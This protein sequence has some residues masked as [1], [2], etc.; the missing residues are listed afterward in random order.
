MRKLKTNKRKFF[1]L[2]LN[3]LLSLSKATIAYYDSERKYHDNCAARRTIVLVD[4]FAVARIPDQKR[5]VLG[6]YTKEDLLAT[7][8]DDEKQ[9]NEWLQAIRSILYRTPE[10]H[11]R[12]L[13]DFQ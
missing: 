2:R 11:C 6:I 8:C 1:V 4:C 5:F 3:S 9:L 7:V 10:Y 12:P 13:R